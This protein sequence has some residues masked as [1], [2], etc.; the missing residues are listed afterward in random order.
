[1]NDEQY[2]KLLL[3][4]LQNAGFAVSE[5]FRYGDDWQM[6]SS[7]EA[8]FDREAA[9][10]F[11]QNWQPPIAADW[12]VFRLGLLSNPAY[13]RCTLAISQSP[14]GMLLIQR[15]E[16]AAAMAEPPIAVIAM[17][18]RQMISALPKEY[19]PNSEEIDQWRAI[20]AAA[21][22]PFRFDEHGLIA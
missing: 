11:V 4:A 9:W 14:A 12:G 2:G 22:V 16:N 5:F 20:A 19:Q 18:W 6:I 21:N 10:A 7:D 17:L 1:M 15:L 8:N 3:A 13:Q